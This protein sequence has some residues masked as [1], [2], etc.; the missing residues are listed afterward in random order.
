M[1]RGKKLPDTN[2]TIYLS[3]FSTIF[4]IFSRFDGHFRSSGL[5]NVRTLVPKMVP[6]PRYANGE[7]DFPPGV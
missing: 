1:K 4:C 3:F 6:S 2:E 5:G 7:T